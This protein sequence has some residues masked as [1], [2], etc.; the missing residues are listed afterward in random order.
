MKHLMT[1]SAV[2]A[3]VTSILACL[4]GYV[5]LGVLFG[6]AAVVNTI[7]AVVE[8]KKGQRTNEA[9]LALREYLTNTKK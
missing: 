5:L 4:T 7:D 2:L 1:F 9:V 6:L 8:H 3:A